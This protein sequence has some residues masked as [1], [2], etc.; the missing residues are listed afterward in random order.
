MNCTTSLQTCKNSKSENLRGRENNKAIKNKMN[1]KD[2]EFTSKRNK[3]SSLTI[4]KR[5]M[6]ICIYNHVR[7]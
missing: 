6:Y 3:S 1:D 4:I 5:F 7:D 2:S